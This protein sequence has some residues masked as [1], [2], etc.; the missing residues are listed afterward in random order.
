MYF[1]MEEKH[2]R[3]L[4]INKNLAY[5]ADSGQRN[6][7]YGKIMVNYYSLHRAFLTLAQVYAK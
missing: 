5:W 4:Q 2:V 1:F 6:Q 3:S 7:Q